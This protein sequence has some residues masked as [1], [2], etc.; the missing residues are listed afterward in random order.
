M[1]RL[2]FL[3]SL[4]VF[5]LPATGQIYRCQDAEGHVT[6][7]NVTP[8]KKNCKRMHL[9]PGTPMPAPKASSNRASPSS[10]SFPRVDPDTQRARD[11]GRRQILMQELESE[12]TQLE[13]AQQAL[14]EQEKIRTGNE[15]N[16]Q[17]V[18][19]RLQ[20]YKD[21]VSRHQRNIEAINKEISNLR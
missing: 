18:L 15:K 9:D 10:G 7:S 2:I 13:T 8:N 5:C 3:A 11:D 14:A 17:R 4:A 6:Y 20:P 19:D 21:E 1:K 16:Y 12:K